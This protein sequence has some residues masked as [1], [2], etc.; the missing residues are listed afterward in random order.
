[1]A[2]PTEEHPSPIVVAE[3][4]SRRYALEERRMS[5]ESGW[6]G[7]V[8]GSAASAPT[9]IAGF[10]VCLLVIIISIVG[11][12]KLPTAEFIERVIPIITL[13]LGYLFGKKSE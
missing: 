6:L 10:V 12:L 13:A 4:V 5:L 7:T 9:N 8:F 1:M 11:L 2:E 3:D